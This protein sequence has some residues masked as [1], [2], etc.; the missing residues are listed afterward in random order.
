M[1]H[2]GEKC[3]EVFVGETSRKENL[4][5][6]EREIPEFIFRMR[7]LRLNLYCSGQEQLVGFYEHD[8]ECSG[9]PINVVHFL[10]G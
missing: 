4:G 3:V 10:T 6:F 9:F 2:A 8:N 1:W 5:L 7:G